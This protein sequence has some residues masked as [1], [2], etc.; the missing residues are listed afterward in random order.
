MGR[1]D[2][3]SIQSR[4]VSWARLMVQRADEFGEP[5]WKLLR[6][7][8]SVP[9]GAPVSEQARRR[10][11]AEGLLSGMPDLCLPV[12]RTAPVSLSMADVV[13]LEAHGIL[14]IETK[15]A[16]GQLSLEQC[17]VIDWLQVAGH[18]VVVARSQQAI[19]KALRAWIM[20]ERDLP[21]QVDVSARL[22]KLRAI[23][24][25]PPAPRA[26]RAG[27]RS[28]AAKVPT[29]S[30][31]RASSKKPSARSKA[32]PAGRGRNQRANGRAK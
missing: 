18:Y 5:R 13:P 32:A 1:F 23:T 19:S 4:A 6:L 16:Q 8:H 29:A 15:T 28:T 12:V 10:L 21:P 7:L 9:N 20:D 22:A 17:R 24:T 11:V 31:T 14:Y 3:S 27:S 2:E 25:T 26:S 30:A